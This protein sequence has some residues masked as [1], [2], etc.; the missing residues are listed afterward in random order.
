M[1]VRNQLKLLVG[2]LSARR[3]GRKPPTHSATREFFDRSRVVATGIFVLTVTAIVLV[4]SA[5]LT[6]LNVPVL[7]NQLATARVVAATPFSYPSVEQTSAASEQL[8]NRLPP[9]YR[10][11]LEPSQRFDAAAR[12]LLSQLEIF[13]HDHTANA[14]L[15]NDRRSDFAAL[16]DA[17][18]A[19]GPLSR[20]RRGCQRRARGRRR[21]GPRRLL[22]D[23]PS[24]PCATSP[25]R[26]STTIISAAPIP[27]MSRSSR[28]CA[29]VARSRSARSSRWK[30]P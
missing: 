21:Q 5:G 3:A 18:N 17:F 14:L 13:E 10:I 22:R 29:R 1:S 8:I 28:S 19:R 2:G 30:R 9:V 16:V 25:L 11:D 20:E 27:A 26:V 6:T 15:L 7:P 4:S 23:R 24:P 12:D